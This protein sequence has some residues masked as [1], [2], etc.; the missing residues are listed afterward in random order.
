MV[1]LTGCIIALNTVDIS[2]PRPDSRG[3]L[4]NPAWGLKLSNGT[5]FTSI[6]PSLCDTKKVYVYKKYSLRTNDLFDSEETNRVKI[7]WSGD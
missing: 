1:V 2:P 5:G 7:N 6:Y 4:K 3:Q